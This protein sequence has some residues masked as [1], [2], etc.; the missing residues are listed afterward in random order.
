MLLFAIG[1]QFKLNSFLLL[2][3]KVL[4]PLFLWLRNLVSQPNG[5][6]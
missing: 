3:I 6:A 1:N 2:F 5:R 4:S